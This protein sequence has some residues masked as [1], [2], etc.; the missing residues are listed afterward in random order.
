VNR[1]RG[2]QRT[3]LARFAPASSFNNQLRVWRARRRLRNPTEDGLRQIYV[4]CVIA[5]GGFLAGLLESANVRSCTR[6]AGGLAVVVAQADG[7]AAVGGRSK[8]HALG[9]SARCE[10][11][12]GVARSA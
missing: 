9:I 2:R 7:C 5:S 4:D 1:N 10:A 8:L 6:V 12:E 3:G 11:T